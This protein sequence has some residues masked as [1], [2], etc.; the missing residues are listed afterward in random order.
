MTLPPKKREILVPNLSP[1][2]SH[3]ADAVQFGDL[4]FVSGLTPHDEE[5]KLI[6]EGDVEAQARQVLK[7]I[8]MVLKH[9]GAAFDDVLKVTVYLKDVSD[10]QRINPVRKEF[11]GSHKPASTLV[12]VADL[13]LPGMKIEIEAV[14]GLPPQR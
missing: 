6:G 12:E 1:A 7:N 8:G 11:F 3:Y 14:V 13:A 5:G 2:I 10:R 9:V 4:L